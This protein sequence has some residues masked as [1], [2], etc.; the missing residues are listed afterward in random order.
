MN[1]YKAQFENGFEITRNSKR[2]YAAAWAIFQP[3]AERP[4]DYGFSATVEL[5]AKA[6]QARANW[7][8][9]NIAGCQNGYTIH[10]TER[11]GA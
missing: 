4:D 5:A 10:T 3:G 6:G 1:S 9:K 7:L 11:V 8:A 2:N